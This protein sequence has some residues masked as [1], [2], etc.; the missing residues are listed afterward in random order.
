M[1][2]ITRFGHCNNGMGR[3]RDGEWIRFSDM[4]AVLLAVRGWLTQP[5]QNS[6]TTDASDVGALRIIRSDCALAV[7]IIDAAVGSSASRRES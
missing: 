1:T 4:E 6:G 5:V 2:E 7:R 3:A